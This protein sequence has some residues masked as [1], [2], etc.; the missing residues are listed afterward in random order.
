MPHRIVAL[1]ATETAEIPRLVIQQ[2]KLTRGYGVANLELQIKEWGYDAQSDWAEANNF[3][4][5]SVCPTT[6]KMLEYRDLIKIQ[7]KYLKPEASARLAPLLLSNYKAC[8][9][10]FGFTR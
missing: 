3:A 5:A 4:G 10:G 9:I 7:Q 6:G 8:G 1:V 2:Q